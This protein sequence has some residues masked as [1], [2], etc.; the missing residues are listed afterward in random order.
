MRPW[1]YEF[2]SNIFLYY[3]FN[4]YS[5]LEISNSIFRNFNIDSYDV[6]PF[7]FHYYGSS[8]NS[9]SYNIIFDNVIFEN[10]NGNYSENV[11]GLIYVNDHYN[12]R[13]SDCTFTNNIGFVAM[14]Q[15]SYSARILNFPFCDPNFEIAPNAYFL[16]I[17]NS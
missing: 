9:N 16:K 17:Q 14:I 4:T 6:I 2:S 5:T 7:Y 13:I 3:Y 1:P 8:Y 12:I 11:Y 10:M 15:C